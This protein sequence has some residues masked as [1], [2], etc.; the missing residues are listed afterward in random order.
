MLQRHYFCHDL[1]RAFP[2]EALARSDSSNTYDDTDILLGRNN[3]PF[4]FYSGF[5]ELFV[6]AAID[7]LPL[8]LLVP[9]T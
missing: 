3:C 6:L 9:M 7:L 1:N 8:L 2:I 5:A 4:G